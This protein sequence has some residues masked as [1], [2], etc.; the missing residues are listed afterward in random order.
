MADRSKK[1]DTDGQS[2]G[3]GSSTPDTVDQSELKHRTKWANQIS[4]TALNMLVGS[5][6]PD[7]A[8]QSNL[9]KFA[10][11]SRIL[12]NQISNTRHNALFEP[13]VAS[14][15]ENEPGT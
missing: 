7:T 10:I 11:Q 12:A 2:G 14:K 5:Q 8:G 9:K 13:L 3:G 1:L 15:P 4:N 6:A